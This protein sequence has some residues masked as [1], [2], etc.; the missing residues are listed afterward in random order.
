LRRA[1]VVLVRRCYIILLLR[2][3]SLLVFVVFVPGNAT[4]NGTQH[5]MMRHMAG[6]G[7]GKAAAQAA[8]GV[9]G[10]GIA[11]T[12]TGDR[13]QHDRKAHFHIFQLLIALRHGGHRTLSW[14]LKPL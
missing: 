8:D 6:N 10:S 7:T 1:L 4:P 5:T 14:W 12:E 3:I 2:R 11:E 13:Q 9:S